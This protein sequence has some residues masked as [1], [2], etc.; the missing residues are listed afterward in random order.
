VHS[1]KELV[2]T[3][4]KALYRAKRSGRNHVAA[5]R[6]RDALERAARRPSVIPSREDGEESRAEGTRRT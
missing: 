5:E 3:A 6:R 1:A 4:D 2:V